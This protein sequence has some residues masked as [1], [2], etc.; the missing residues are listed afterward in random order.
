[1]DLGLHFRPYQLWKQNKLVLVPL[2][3]AGNIVF[4]LLLIAKDRKPWLQFAQNKRQT[5]A[6]LSA[7]HSAA[8]NFFGKTCNKIKLTSF[9]E[10]FRY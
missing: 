1:M 3:V 4:R 8:D 6:N 2:R 9:Y 5:P 7:Q 10:N